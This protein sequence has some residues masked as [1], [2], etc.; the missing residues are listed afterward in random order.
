MREAYLHRLAYAGIPGEN[1]TSLGSDFL[2]QLVVV[3]ANEQHIRTKLC[4]QEILSVS[5]VP[6]FHHWILTDAL[7]FS[8]NAGIDGS[9]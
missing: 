8:M 7:F 1:D 6:G 9:W 3:R 4:L 5:G 2:K